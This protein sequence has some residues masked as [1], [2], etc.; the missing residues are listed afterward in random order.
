MRCNSPD[1]ISDAVFRN[2]ELM[3]NRPCRVL[4]AAVALAALVFPRPARALELKPYGFVLV[5]A[6]EHWNRPNFL[7]IPTQAVSTD[8]P[9]TRD[10]YSAFHV[11]QT[12]LGLNAKGAVGPA[13]SAASAVVEADFWG[14]RASGSAGNDVLQASPRLRAAAVQLQWE[15]HSLL[16]GQD[17]LKAFSPLNP[18]S[19][20]H[21]AIPPMHNSGNLWNRAPQARW[22]GRFEASDAPAALV[23][24][25]ALARPFSADQAGRT[26][27]GVAAASQPD[28]P[29]SG[30]SAGAP[31]L[32]ALLEASRKLD[33]REF[34]A[35][36][37]GQYLRQRFRPGVAA[38]PAGA[39]SGVADGLLGSAHATLPVLEAFEL[40]GE[41][42]YGRSNMGLQGLGQVYADGS[43]IRTS[44][45]R[46]GW[47]QGTLKPA[48]GWKVHAAHGV[49]KLDETGLAAGRV[50][51]NESSTLNAVWDSS[52]DLSFSAEYGLIRTFFVGKASGRT[53]SLGL[54]AM[55]KL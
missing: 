36:V 13:G 3:M 17:W 33:G 22:E 52:K 47:M 46:G 6:I 5:N 21:Q 16:L 14:N 42:F 30:E 31:A 39:A 7:D 19:L 41:A 10:V 43:R 32:Q 51:R 1:R 35:G 8:D 11:R 55:L 34:S 2:W 9:D 49:E 54:A 25:A 18:A 50:Y 44:R 24:R 27:A 48:A 38:G 4:P 37:S 29:G 53:H 28:Q 23:A 26:T 20:M 12:R 45:T 40:S 15:R